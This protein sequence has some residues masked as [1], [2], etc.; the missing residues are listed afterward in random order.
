MLRVALIGYGNLAEEIA[1]VSNRL[2]NAV[3]VTVHDDAASAAQFI[4]GRAADI[5][6]VAVRAA[7]GGRA[8]IARAA[9][10]CGKHVLLAAPFCESVEDADKLADEA[11]AGGLKLRADQSQHWHPYRRTIKGSLAVGELGEPGLLRIH[12]WFGQSN[13][14]SRTLLDQAFHASDVFDVFGETPERVFA[15]GNGLKSSS[16]P[17]DYLQVHLGFRNGGSALIDVAHIDTPYGYHNVSLIAAEGAAY[18]DDHSN[19]HLVFDENGTNAADGGPP[20][21]LHWAAQLDDFASECLGESNSQ[22]VN[23]VRRSHLTALT[24]IESL[25]EQKPVALA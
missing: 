18:A 2:R 22:D 13:A 10:D 20:E 19:A 16:E 25:R 4:A 3:L 11:A 9:F 12:H 17:L 24:V 7:L 21:M 8:A 6:A 14:E 23:A 15:V 5:D 1:A